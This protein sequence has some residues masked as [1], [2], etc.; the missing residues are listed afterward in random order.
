MGVQLA[1]V[2]IAVSTDAISLDG[3]PEGEHVYP[4]EHEPKNRPLG[5]PFYDFDFIWGCIVDV[6]TLVAIW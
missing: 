3:I 4:K 1:I 5:N 6:D 2:C